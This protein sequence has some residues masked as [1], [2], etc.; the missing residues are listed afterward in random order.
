MPC[1]DRM[2]MQDEIVSNAATIHSELSF[3]YTIEPIEKPL[4]CL[5]KQVV[6]EEARFPLKRK[7]IWSPYQSSVGNAVVC[8]AGNAGKLPEWVSSEFP[9]DKILQL[10]TYGNRHNWQKQAKGDS[11]CGT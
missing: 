8:D 6:L 2:W 1:P 7:C 9:I 5:R 3:S 11:H 10:Q 4:N